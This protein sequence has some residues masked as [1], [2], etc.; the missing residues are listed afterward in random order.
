[1]TQF[2]SQVYRKVEEA[3]HFILGTPNPGNPRAPSH[4]GG[5]WRRGACESAV[6]WGQC[7][8]WAV[9]YT[10]QTCTS[11]ASQLY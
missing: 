9:G 1:M 11:L 2:P 5:R 6:S 3:G 8:H 10:S 4:P 7:L